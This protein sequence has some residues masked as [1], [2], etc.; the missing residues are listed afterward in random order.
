VVDARTL[1]VHGGLLEA[2]RV[3]EERDQGAG[4]ARP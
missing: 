4:V 2:E 1:A 3:D